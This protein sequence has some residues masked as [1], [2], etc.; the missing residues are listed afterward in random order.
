[1]SSRLAVL[2]EHYAGVYMTSDFLTSYDFPTFSPKGVSVVLLVINEKYF[3]V[4]FNDEFVNLLGMPD[5]SRKTLVYSFMLL[6]KIFC[7]KMI[8]KATET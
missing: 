8:A 2:G 1:M 6:M 3:R 4:R 5:H 7:L